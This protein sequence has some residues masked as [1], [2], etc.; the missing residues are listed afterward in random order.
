MNYRP[1]V[2]HVAVPTYLDPL[3]AVLFAGAFVAAALIARRRPA[4]GLGALLLAT[5]FDFSRDVL[6]TTIT[7]PKCVLLGVLLALTTVPS[8]WRGL[9]RP[10]SA[11]ILG[12]LLLYL[13]VTVASAAG[14]AH[15]GPVARESLKW[16]EY[17]ALFAVAFCCYRLDADDDALLT[18]AA[19][20]A[21]AVCISAL[22]QEFAGAPSGLYIGSAIVPR[23]AGLL[24]G[25]NQL[26]AYCS[27][28]AA[29]FGAWAIVRP[30]PLRALALGLVTFAAILTFSRAGIA[31][32]AVVFLLLVLWGGRRALTG[33]RPAIVGAVAGAAGCAWWAFYAHTPGVLRISLAPSAYAG[34]VGNRDELWRAAWRMFLARPLLGVGAGNFE[35]D[36][37]QFGL[38]GVRTHANS[39]YLQSL[40]EGGIVL[41]GATLALVVA[42]IGAFLRR[43]FLASLRAQ[44]PWVVAAVAA[45]I[46]LALHQIVDDFVFYPKVAAPWLL[47][48]G[49]AAAARRTA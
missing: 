25:P 18:C 49:I 15:A 20:A 7:L 31:T 29:V 1:V 48:L 35:L 39:W 44:S 33:L 24:E 13:V 28:A 9:R 46:A 11:P 32:L 22:A 10:P 47:L 36:L 3:S 34:G 19:L 26:A 5:P 2:D 16:L 8:V 40:A 6:A 45:S 30:L 27:V 38:Y 23:I 14:A 17:A 37:P 12:A 4:Y 42:S 41:F 43:P 21:I